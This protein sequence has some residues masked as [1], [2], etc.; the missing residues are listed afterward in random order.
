MTAR[1]ESNH[2]ISTERSIRSNPPKNLNV[3]EA[4]DYIGISPRYLR[5]LIAERKIRVVRIG[6]RVMLR[7]IDVDRWM[8]SKTEGGV[9]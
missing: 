9:L 3:P 6:H 5:S 2:N 7:L 4:A 8:E 1:K